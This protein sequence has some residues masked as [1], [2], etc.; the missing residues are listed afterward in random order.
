MSLL[1][2]RCFIVSEI[3]LEAAYK[4]R[5]LAGGYLDGMLFVGGWRRSNRSARLCQ[6]KKV[7]QNA[8]VHSRCGVWVNEEDS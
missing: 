6:E 1:D 5:L 2:G 3:S 8:R 7:D 4:A